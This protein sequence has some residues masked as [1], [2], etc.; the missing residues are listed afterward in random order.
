MAKTETKEYL[1]CLAFAYFIRNNNYKN[2]PQHKEEWINLFRDFRVGNIKKEYGEYLEYN[3]DYS[4]LKAKYNFYDGL[5]N[6]HLSAVH[7]QMVSLFDS[8]FIDNSKQ[9][10]VY[11]QDSSFVQTVKDKC[12]ERL[13]KIFSESFSSKSK[14]KDL[15][16]AD[17]YIVDSSKINDIKK[18]FNQ[19]IINPK[20]DTTILLNYKKDKTKT[21][22]YMLLE[23]FKKKE[24]IP[25]S[26]K[27][28][29][30]RDPMTSAK[31]GGNIRNIG[32]GID[33]KNIDPYSQLVVLL[34]SK[35]PREVEKII[36]G[37]IDIKYDKWDIRES[38]SSST[39]KLIFDFNY[40]K[41][42]PNFDDSRFSL[43]PLPS[44]G[45]GS[46][47][48]KFYIQKGGTKMTPW[49]AGMAPRSLEPFLKS[50]SGYNN[51]MM[52]LSKKRINVFNDIIFNEIL[53]QKRNR[54]EAN[55][56]LTSIKNLKEYQNCTRVL[57]D[58]KFHTFSELKSKMEPFFNE[59]EYPDGFEMF[60][61]EMIRKIRTEGGFRTNVDSI[62]SE[63]LSEHYISLQMS[64]F[65]FVGGQSF[66]QFLKKSIFFT[67]FGAITKRG[68]NKISG[69]M[70][71]L[72]TKKFSNK[73]MY[74]DVEV[75]L[76]SA[77][78]IILL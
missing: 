31:I 17:F 16:P 44:G 42:D 19:S 62:K 21:Y 34:G 24:L 3:F 51:I 50:Y 41:I 43:E 53:K 61:K 49:V 28:P 78:H 39:W 12:L 74:K 9:Y 32:K 66:R 69:G 10:K 77:P 54:T 20:N 14:A 6:P 59:I 11:T 70:T 68:I 45:S 64:Y 58:R 47:N 55:K 22:E 15:T 4:K 36:D 2:N 46:F 73:K 56:E 75:S 33:K 27:M 67:I 23:Y 48:G 63:R 71:N 35:S 30:D 52:L 57:S 18:D 40:K 7:N 38:N 8:G 1:A 60:Q 26:H 25:V 29:E 13:H 5:G 76:T 37:V 72:I 65:L